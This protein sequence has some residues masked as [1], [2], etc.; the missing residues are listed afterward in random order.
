MQD[1][2]LK[3][4]KGIRRLL[5]RNEKGL[6]RTI[7]LIEELKSKTRAAEQADEAVQRYG[8]APAKKDESIQIAPNTY[9][10]KDFDHGA[11]REQ[12]YYQDDD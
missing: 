6:A 10:H 2:N 8:D 5:K 7:E 9:Y 12:G 1:K 4:I 11:P 3:I